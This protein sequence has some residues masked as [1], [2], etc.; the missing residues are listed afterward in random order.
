MPKSKGRTKK[1]KGKAWRTGRA[2][3]EYDDGSTDSP[4]GLDFSLMPEG[5]AEVLSAA[6]A[7]E[8]FE[9]APSTDDKLAGKLIRRGWVPVVF[10][11]PDD[12]WDMWQWPPSSPGL[13][14]WMATSISVDGGEYLVD[15][16]DPYTEDGPV[17]YETRVELLDDIDAIEAYRH[18]A[19]PRV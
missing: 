12:R 1:S 6:L 11:S 8:E 17:T 7:E 13:D 10:E 5:L 15:F 14:G 16:A 4:P 18:P 9:Q 3:S 2:G 19:D